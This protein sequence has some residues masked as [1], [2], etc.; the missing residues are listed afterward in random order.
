MQQLVRTRQEEVTGRLHALVTYLQRLHDAVERADSVL[1]GSPVTVPA[2]PAAVTVAEVTSYAAALAEADETA[3]TR[4]SAEAEAAAGEAA[5]RLKRLSSAAARLA[6]GT[7]SLPAV[8][9]PAGDALL[10]PSSLD[11]VVSAETTARDA[12]NRH[13]ADQHTAEGQ[14]ERAAAL[15]AA[16]GR[17]RLSAVDSLY[18]LLADAKFL[19]HLTDRR[20]GPCS[21]SPARRSAPY[22]AESSGSPP[23][24]RSSA[25][26]PRRPAARRPCRAEKPS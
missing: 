25:A 21:P 2:R 17:S 6:A 1:S 18:G 9:L 15:D 19:K 26:A 24:S 14:F 11:A 3:A 23:I 20:A 5:A 12:A 8:A 4:L 16:L 10:E 13:R 7:D 22:L